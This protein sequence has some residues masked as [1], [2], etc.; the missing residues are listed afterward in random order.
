MKYF[1]IILILLF[2][3]TTLLAQPGLP[4]PPDQAPLHT[5]LYL[6][7][8]IISGYGLRIWFGR[9]NGEE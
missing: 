1:A 7:M 2:C 9:R 4:N 6:L 3:T 5:G 8:A